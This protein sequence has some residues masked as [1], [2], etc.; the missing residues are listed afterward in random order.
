MRTLVV[1]GLLA[2]VMILGS[3]TPSDAATFLGLGFLDGS[4]ESFATAISADGS[5][6]VGKTSSFEG[7]KAFRWDATD[8]MQDLG[9]LSGGVVFAAAYGVSSDGTTIVGSSQST[10]GAEAFRWD[11]TNGM[12]GIGD[13][14]GGPFSSISRGV[15][16]D[17]SI[18]LG[19]G[20]SDSRRQAFLWDAING[21]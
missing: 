17:G 12:Q 14:P 8:G 18:V 11:A 7:G 9:N 5:T 6:V 16:A 20:L 3:G 15:S 19:E 1:S 21:I 4:P 2:T 10:F 13:I